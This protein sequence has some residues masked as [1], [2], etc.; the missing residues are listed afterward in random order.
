MQPTELKQLPDWL[1]EQLSKITEPAILLLRDTK[2]EVD[3]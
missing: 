3:K 2:L 1:L